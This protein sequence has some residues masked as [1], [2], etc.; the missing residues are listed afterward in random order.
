MSFNYS[1]HRVHVPLHGPTALIQSRWHTLV[2]FSPSVEIHMA[3][4]DVAS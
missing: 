2:F 3:N 1:C 4:S